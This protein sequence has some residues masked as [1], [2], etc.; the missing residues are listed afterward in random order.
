[1]THAH[2]EMGS[3]VRVC[4]G[5]KRSREG[6]FIEEVKLTDDVRVELQLENS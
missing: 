6:D 3:A 1:M 5:V 4:V 2:G